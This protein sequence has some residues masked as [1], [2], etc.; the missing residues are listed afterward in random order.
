VLGK[1]PNRQGVSQTIDRG[2]PHV[3]QHTVTRRGS[4]SSVLSR[5]TPSFTAGRTSILVFVGTFRYAQVR[6]VT[7]NQGATVAKYQVV[8][9]AE[10]IEP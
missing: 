9:N 4:R 3:W 6:T 2:H 5:E 1:H 7:P 10:A 8:M